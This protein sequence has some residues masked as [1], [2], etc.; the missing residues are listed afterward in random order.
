MVDML[1]GAKLRCI[2]KP[3]LHV[4]QPTNGHVTEADSQRTG[5][6]LP[7]MLRVLKGTVFAG[8]SPTNVCAHH[9][10]GCMVCRVKQIIHMALF[11]VLHT[12][13]KPMRTRVRDGTLAL[14]TK[15]SASM[16]TFLYSMVTLGS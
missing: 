6:S 12:C 5:L 15:A 4:S 3:A 10:P 1:H 14:P 11:A 7:L 8:D 16:L 13:K 2:A 9:P